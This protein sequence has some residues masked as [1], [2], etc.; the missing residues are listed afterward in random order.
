MWRILLLFLRAFVHTLLGRLRE[1]PIR[2]SW[3][4]R[5][6][7]VVRGLRM[8]W[9]E[10]GSWPAFRIREE[11][12]GRFYPPVKGVGRRAEEVGVAGEWFEPSGAAERPVLVYFHGG[13]YLFGSTTT[14]ADLLARIATASGMRT[15]APNYRLAPEHPYPAQLE[16][17]LAVYD[18][19][20]ARD[21]PANR[22]VLAGESAGG[23]L[24]LVTALA[25]RDR[26]D[27]LPAAAAVFSPWSDL[28]ASQASMDENAPYDYGSKE[29]LLGQAKQFAG[30]L[31]LD[32]PRV[33]PLYA[34]LGGLPPLRIHAGEA[35]LLFDE[36]KALAERAREAGVD[37]TFEP[38]PDMPHAVELLAQL[39][40]EGAA[41]IE[42][43]GEWLKARAMPA[44]E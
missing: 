29:M 40:P 33:S 27:P 26:G 38:M 3:S 10:M 23:N 44:K 42:Q 17:A 30:E 12:E 7:W 39:C 14:H 36:C 28:S 16:D 5:F 9:D 31:A 18:A 13:S 11:L 37:V 21:I 20:R 1:G 2:A 4:F 19:L 32:D 43:A 6:E 15:F 41:A 8:D 22:I 34:D 25:L 35:E 24:A